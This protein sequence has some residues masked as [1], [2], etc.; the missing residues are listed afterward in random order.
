[1]DGPEVVH[2]FSERADVY[3]NANEAGAWLVDFSG[4]EPPVL[5]AGAC[6]S[7]EAFG[8]GGST[9]VGWCI[10]KIWADPSADFVNGWS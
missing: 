9:I 4:S 6:G 8:G 1:M 5:F 7:A 10:P 2:V 3:A